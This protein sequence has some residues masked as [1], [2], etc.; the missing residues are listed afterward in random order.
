LDVQENEFFN[1]G[2]V[3]FEPT[4]SRYLYWLST[5]GG[6][7]LLGAVKIIITYSGVYRYAVPAVAILFPRAHYSSV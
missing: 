2:Y 3:T 6:D 5:R 1:V 7:K 4:P